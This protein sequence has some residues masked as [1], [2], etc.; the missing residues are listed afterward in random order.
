MI[1]VIIISGFLG[2][3]KTT[4]LSRILKAP[5]KTRYA[6][7]INEFGEVGLDQNLIPAGSDFVELD[8]GCLCCA[9]NEDL[10]KIIEKLAARSDYDAIIVE[11]TGIADPLATAWTF[12]RPQFKNKFRISELICV[13]DALHVDIT[14]K[15]SRET[16]TQIASADFL[17]VAKT[18]VGDLQKILGTLKTINPHAVIVDSQNPKALDV[19]LDHNLVAHKMHISSPHTHTDYKSKSFDLSSQNLTLAQMEDIIT[20]L[21]AGVIRAKAAFKE[22]HTG[23]IYILHRVASRLDFYEKP[24]YVGPYALVTIGKD[25]EDISL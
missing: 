7:I 25:I 1:P 23:K 10:V 14:K 4:L 13:V 5:Q 18:D 20:G 17:Y 8:N 21:P 22:A 12:T 19:L 16:E 24:D 9:L 6:L 11:T 15:I 2:S 3:G